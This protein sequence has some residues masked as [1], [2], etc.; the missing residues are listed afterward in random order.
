MKANGQFTNSP[1]FQIRYRSCLFLEQSFSFPCD[2]RGTW[3]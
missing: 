1:N 2:A 3:I